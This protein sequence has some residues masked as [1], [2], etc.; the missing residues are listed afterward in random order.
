MGVALLLGANAQHSR[1]GP[2]VRVQAGRYRVRTHGLL[3][4]KLALRLGSES[5][6]ELPD[7]FDLVIPTNIQIDFVER[8]SENS[9]S[10]FAERE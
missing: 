6:G 3:E 9:I 4:S 2:V 5:T 1:G 10:V 7:Q 8:G